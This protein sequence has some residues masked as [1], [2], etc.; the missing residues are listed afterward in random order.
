LYIKF[1]KW[2]KCNLQVLLLKHTHLHANI[3]FYLAQ[4]S[5][6]II[7]MII[8]LL[9]LPCNTCIYSEL[10]VQWF[11]HILT[12]Y[13]N[14]LEMIP[15][16]EQP[17]DDFIIKISSMLYRYARPPT[18]YKRLTYCTKYSKIKTTRSIIFIRPPRCKLL[19]LIHNWCY[20]LGVNFPFWGE[21]YPAPPPKINPAFGIAVATFTVH[22]YTWSDYTKSAL[23]ISFFTL[24]YA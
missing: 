1:S 23:Y 19:Q 3:T 7:S 2:F 14:C 21:T 24:G 22:N 18:S 6:N 13:S 8:L 16:T 12:K 20:W 17:F 10:A 11:N 15:M 9:Q 4:C 5:W